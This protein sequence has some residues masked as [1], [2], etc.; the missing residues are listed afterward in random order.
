ML[1]RFKISLFDKLF[2][3]GLSIALLV[4]SIL[5]PPFQSPDE[6]SH[7]N[8]AYTISNGQILLTNNG[9][10]LLDEKL[11]HFESIFEVIP[12]HYENKNSLGLERSSKELNWTG[13]LKEVELSNVAVYFPL[14]YVPQSAGVAIGRILDISI[15]D[16]YKLSKFITIFLCLLGIYFA[17]RIYPISPLGYFVLSMPMTIFQIS[18]TSPDG[19][20]FSLSAIIGA[21]LAKALD[22][23]KEFT[24]KELCIFSLLCFVICTNK[25][26][27]FPI[28][29]FYFLIL[30]V[31]NIDFGRSLFIF[32]LISIVSWNLFSYSSFIGGEHFSARAEIGVTDKLKFY[33]YNL[34]ALF[35]VFF[36]TFS[37][38][39]TNTNTLA[40]FV[41]VLGWLDAPLPSFNYVVLIL[42]GLSIL[43]LGVGK[44][45]DVFNFTI[46]LLIFLAVILGTY[47]IL[48]ITWTPLNFEVIQGVQGRYFIPLALIFSYM[49]Y[50]KGNLVN[51]SYR[52]S[53]IALILSTVFTVYT[54]TYRYLM[55]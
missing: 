14:S 24:F 40:Q 30:R 21:L 18:S 48:L 29:L 44:V 20:I 43:F 7:F 4:L 26:N 39:E 2:L 6:I 32:T 33:I 50:P 15:Y 42:I 16:S 8:R 12:F 11:I 17:S 31:R 34:G 5:V 36:N 13:N 53:L 55:G 46:N 9:K 45:N 35:K 28:L 47:F 54:I 10:G 1:F 23:S 52:M 38:L 3:L 51:L 19:V 25:I 37:S 22:K 27:M 49:F 41:G